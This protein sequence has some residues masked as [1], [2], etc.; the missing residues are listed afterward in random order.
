M[1]KTFAIWALV[2]SIALALTACAGGSG[3]G[4]SGTDGGGSAGGASQGSSQ[5]KVEI[6][7]YYPVAVGG[8]I[9]KLF[10]QLANDFMA[11]NENIVVKPIYAG[12]YQDT[13]TKVTTAVQGGNPPD[14][15][16]LLSTELYTLL[17][18]DAVEELTNLFPQEFWNDFYEGFMGN[19]KSG[20]RIWSVPFQRSTIVLYY[21]KDKFREAG[22]IRRSRRPTG[23]SW[24]NTARS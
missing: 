16:V 15:A 5:K 24:W 7:F 13:M 3:S 10:D 4:S 11:E 14:L 6:E 21:N 12:S 20:D 1:R 2:L 23:R 17:E 9:Q 22:W 19:T 18:M 8:P